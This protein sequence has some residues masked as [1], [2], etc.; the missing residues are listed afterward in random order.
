M[1]RSSSR[2]LSKVKLKALAQAF[3][4]EAKKEN[5]DVNSIIEEFDGY[6]DLI[7][8]ELIDM[9]KWYSF[10]NLLYETTDIIEDRLGFTVEKVVP[11]GGSFEYRWDLTPTKW[12]CLCPVYTSGTTNPA[13]CKLYV[14]LETYTPSP[15]TVRSLVVV[16]PEQP[17]CHVDNMPPLPEG[18]YYVQTPKARGIIVFYNDDPANDAYC[19]FHTDFIPAEIE[20]ARR[21][22]WHIKLPLVNTIRRVLYEEAQV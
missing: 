22:I 10:L 13:Y 17:M 18:F 8:Q 20:I 1:E 9:R 16:A 5:P 3:A 2:N 15:F 12:A 7:R 14:E 19:I 6:L 11:A 4:E 21:L